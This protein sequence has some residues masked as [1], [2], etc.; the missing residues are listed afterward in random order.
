MTQKIVSP[1]LKANELVE[2]FFNIHPIYRIG[3]GE[4][5]YYYAKIYALKCADY[6]LSA[7]YPIGDADYWYAVQSE[8]EMI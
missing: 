5:N 2:N 1:K 3:D 6:I 4:P 8:I 7:Q